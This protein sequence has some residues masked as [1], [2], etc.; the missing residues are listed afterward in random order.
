MSL[1]NTISDGTKGIIF[2]LF[3]I[4]L[5]SVQDIIVKVLSGI[6]ELPLHQL[7][8]MRYVLALI[9][10]G[11]LVVLVSSYDGLKTKHFGKQLL[12]GVFAFTAGLSYYLALA[13]LPVAET[14]AI[15]FSAPLFVTLLSIIFLKEQVGI[16]RWMAIAVGFIGVLIMVR[17]GGDVFDPMAL[18]VIVSAMCYAVSMLLARAMGSTESAVNMSFYS[19]VV[20]LFGAGTVAVLASFGAFSFLGTNDN[21][22]FLTREWVLP[23]GIAWIMIA[24]VALI[25]VVSFHFITQAY[26]I[27][28]PSILALFEYTT[29]F[30]AVLWGIT[31]FSEFPD[32]WTIVGMVLVVMA[33][34]YT[35]ARESW[36]GLGHKKWIT[37][38]ALHRYR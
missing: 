17:P 2:A 36:A 10:F 32:Q 6:S 19:M 35:I 15:F 9:M 14:V 34:L 8:V 20:N 27:T 23:D 7:L 30:W 21:F 16:H 18:L 25:T 4:A 1:F 29:M 38:R 13:V 31:F 37:G 24:A 12:R 5:I 28:S 26:R 22:V 11:W 3:A 33:G